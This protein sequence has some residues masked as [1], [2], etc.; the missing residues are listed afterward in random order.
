MIARLSGILLEKQLDG[1]VV[2][3]G[4][5][6][7]QVAVSLNTLSVLP[8]VGQPVELFTHLHVREDAM[9]LYGFASRDER[10]AFLLCTAV[11]GIGP[12]LGLSLLS[13]LDAASL[14]AAVAA[15]DVARLRKVPGIGPKTAERLIIELRDKVPKT[16]ATPVPKQIAAEHVGLYGEVVGALVQLGYRAGDAER[17][18]GVALKEQDSAPIEHVLRRALRALQRD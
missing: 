6:G 10:K 13:S 17:A 4:G 15:D 1:V 9:L 7:Y 2:D 12:K 11:S 5:V 18:T 16:A 14:F 8:A 3:V